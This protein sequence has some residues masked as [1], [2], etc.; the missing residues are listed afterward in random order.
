MIMCVEHGNAFHAYMLDTLLFAIR[1]T[2]T[3]LTIARAQDNSVTLYPLR[4]AWRSMQ[5][6]V[7]PTLRIRLASPLLYHQTRTRT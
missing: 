7:Q 1:D 2:Q 5:A 4:R 6:N 3:K